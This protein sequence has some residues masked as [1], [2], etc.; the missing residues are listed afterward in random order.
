MLREVWLPKGFEFLAGL[1]EQQ[2]RARLIVIVQAYIDDSGTKNDGP[3]MVLASMI[4][5]AETWAHVSTAWERELNFRSGGRIAYFKEDEA[6]HLSGEFSHWRPEVRDAKVKRLARIVNR[7]DVF[8]A[9]YGLDLDAHR[10]AAQFAGK[11]MR[12][13]KRH[14]GNQPYLLLLPTVLMA[15]ALVARE[16]FPNAKRLELIIDEQNVFAQ[17]MHAFYPGI[18][19]TLGKALG[20]DVF[21][22][23]PS[24]LMFRDDKEFLPLQ[25]ADLMAGHIRRVALADQKCL[26]T[27]LSAIKCWPSSQVIDDKSMVAFAQAFTPAPLIGVKMPRPPRKTSKK[28]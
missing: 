15:A 28:G 21:D 13:A 26:R 23:M 2:R 19:D 17:E 20:G 12:D 3:L 27:D 7:S 24:Q 1:P 14:G 18:R 10:S 8:G 4:G 6:V 11:P 22:L 9:W 25:A 5:S 16:K